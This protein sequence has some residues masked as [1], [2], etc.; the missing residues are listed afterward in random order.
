MIKGVEQCDNQYMRVLL[1]QNTQVK[2]N[3]KIGGDYTEL[4]QKMIQ[5]LTPLVF[6]VFIPVSEWNDKKYCIG[7]NILVEIGG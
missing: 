1:V 4:A 2:N 5:N 3:I 7:D 6:I